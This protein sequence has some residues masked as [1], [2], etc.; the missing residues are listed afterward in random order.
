LVKFAQP[1]DGPNAGLRQ[2]RLSAIASSHLRRLTVIVVWRL[3]R[4]GRSLPDL[5]VT[6]RELIDLGVGFVSL[7]AAL[8]LNTPAGREMAKNYRRLGSCSLKP[9]CSSERSRSRRCRQQ[10][11]T[12]P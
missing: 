5:V 8:D 3:D 10:A 12:N 4:W 6:L 1:F 7:S 9:G 2:R 11:P